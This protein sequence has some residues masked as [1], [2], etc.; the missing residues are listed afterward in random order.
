MAGV[1]TPLSPKDLDKHVQAGPQPAAGP[2]RLLPQLHLRR[3]AAIAHASRAKTTR[4]L[5]PGSA[6]TGEEK[7]LRGIHGA[8]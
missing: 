3:H 6:R 1:V 4:I 2:P 7:T 8:E 5:L